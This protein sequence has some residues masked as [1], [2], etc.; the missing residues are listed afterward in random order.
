MGFYTIDLKFEIVFQTTDPANLE[1]RYIFAEESSQR[2]EFRNERS[3]F[4]DNIAI[5]SVKQGNDGNVVN[6]LGFDW[7]YKKNNEKDPTLNQIRLGIL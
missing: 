1:Q 6:K 4:T 2:R 5:E 3:R 7:Y